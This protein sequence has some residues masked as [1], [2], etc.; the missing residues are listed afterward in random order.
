MPFYSKFKAPKQHFNAQ[1]AY[2]NEDLIFIYLKF[3]VQQKKI[4]TTDI[5]P[6]FQ[7]R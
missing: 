7:Y 3:N 5:V 1:I 4:D 6:E 2:I